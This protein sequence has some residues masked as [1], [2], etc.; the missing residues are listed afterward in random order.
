MYRMIIKGQEDLWGK[1]GEL[2][3]MHRSKHPETISKEIANR[4]GQ[5]PLGETLS[6][7]SLHFVYFQYNIMTLFLM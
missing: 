2:I 1:E 3:I 5:H 4:R 6:G 7:L